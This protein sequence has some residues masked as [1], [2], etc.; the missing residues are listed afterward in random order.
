[1]K[2]TLSFLLVI[3]ACTKLWSQG[4]DKNKVAEYFQNEQYDEAINYLLPLLGNTAD[5]F[6]S[7][8]IGY[9]YLMNEDFSKAEAFYQRTYSMDSTNFTANKQLAQI[10]SEREDY[11]QALVYHKRMLQLQPMNASL[12]KSTAELFRIL[13]ETDS[14]MIYYSRSYNL[15][16]LNIKYASAYVVQLLNQKKY[17]TADS[18][19]NIFLSIDSASVPAMMLAIRSEY[20]KGDYKAATAFSNRW[21]NINTRDRNLSTTIRLAIANYEL[22]S[23]SVSYKLCDTLMKQETLDENLSY[24][25]ARALTKLGDYR[26]SNE[27]YEECLSLAISKNAEKYLFGKVENFE[28]LRQHKLAIAACDTAY[29]LF[30][31]PLALYNIGRLY[32]TGLKNQPKA[33]TYYKQYL[34][35][36][37]PATAQEKKVYS[38]IKEMLD[39]KEKK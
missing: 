28:S 29:Y 1:M 36:A 35:K 38:Y 17:K 34:K 11:V 37:S 6:T 5:V 31:N 13:K 12:H 33:N 7:N 20:E 23:F 30:H 18:I 39:A 15:Q 24:Y 19:L 10:A 14:A 8:A 21:L 4:A 32:E 22:D 2:S 3:I 16:P 25:A 27:L 26:K 9:A